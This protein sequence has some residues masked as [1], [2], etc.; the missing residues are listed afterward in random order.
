M[1]DCYGKAQ[2]FY[3]NLQNTFGIDWKWWFIPTTP[4]IRYNLFEKLYTI[5]QLKKLRVFEED[6]SDPEGKEF[7]MLK[8]SIDIEKTVVMVFSALAFAS[9]LLYNFEY[10]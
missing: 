4:L 1:K 3:K 2:P 5:K 8:K 10:I 9:F 7:A 6:D